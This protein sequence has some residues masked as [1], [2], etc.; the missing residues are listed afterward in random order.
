MNLYEAQ[1]EL[2]QMFN[3]NQLV[4][5]IS[6][7]FRECEEFDFVNFFENDCEIDAD[8]GISILT[9]LAIHK[10]A[11]LPTMVGCLRR[12]STDLQPIANALEILTEKGLIDWDEDDEVFTVKLDV[13]QEVQNEIDTYQ[14]P[15]PMV[16]KPRVLKSNM[17][18]GYLAGHRSIILKNNHHDGDVCL[19]HLNRM[20]SITLSI[21]VDVVNMIQNSWKNLDKQKDDETRADYL[22]RVRAFQR[23]DEASHTAMA[24]MVQCG[25]KFHLTHRP[26]K[27]GRTYSQGYHI[28]YQ[29]NS[30]NKAVVVLHFGEVV[31]GCKSN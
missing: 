28:N 1:M 10:K 6:K 16:V 26:D 18:T 11:N 14:F 27:R 20:N 4:P 12:G 24:L 29:G 31:E 19:D 23:Y 25:N 13:T 9:Q 15:L 17:D 5:R 2:E 30:Y 21:D 22:K 7:E 3:K 8:L